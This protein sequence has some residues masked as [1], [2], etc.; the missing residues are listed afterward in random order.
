MKSRLMVIG[1][2]LASAT[3]ADAQTLAQRVTA[4]DGIVQVLFPARPD[5]CGDG[6]S[7]IR[8]SRGRSDMIVDGDWSARHNRPCVFGQGRLLATVIDGEVTRLNVYVGPVPEN[9]RDTRT[10]SASAPDASA[11][12]VDLAQRPAPRAASRAIQSLM[13]V[14]APTPWPVMVRVARDG[15]RPR[16]VRQSAL[17]WLGTGVTD[18]LGLSDVDE[19]AT[20][21]DEMRTQ[22][23]FVL[24]QR[25]K[26]ESVPEL[27]EIVRTAKNRAVRKAA[28][29]WLGQ[30]GDPRAA[31]VYA[32]LL[33]VR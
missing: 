27:I 6:Q 1:A 20:D 19:R 2:L 3:V 21:D 28:I 30:S 25:P 31:D 18:K 15:S 32:E 23:V 13:F 4:A 29:F 8:T 11:W 17:M 9:A 7:Y 24:S 16:E 12:L 14:D 5:V 33:G 22:A 10:I 26:S